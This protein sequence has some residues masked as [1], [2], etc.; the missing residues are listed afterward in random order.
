MQTISRSTQPSTV[1]RLPADAARRNSSE[2]PSMSGDLQTSVGTAEGPNAVSTPRRF[3]RTPPTH[4]RQAP[5]ESHSF[6]GAVQDA[7]KYPAPTCAPF[8]SQGSRPTF[9]RP[10]NETRPLCGALLLG[11]YTNACINSATW[12]LYLSQLGYVSPCSS[13]EMRRE[14]RSKTSIA[15]TASL[16]LR[17]G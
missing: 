8:Y 15:C 12:A 5:G 13:G 17:G 6:E 4:R 11:N 3:K 14:L 9:A 16:G 7:M 1:L 2:L 10:T